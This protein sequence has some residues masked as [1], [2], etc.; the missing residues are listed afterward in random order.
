[1]DRNLAEKLVTELGK[2]PPLTTRVLSDENYFIDLLVS[3]EVPVS[4]RFY[5]EVKPNHKII[6]D[7]ANDQ[8]HFLSLRRILR[9]NLAENYKLSK[10]KKVYE[11]LAS[12]LGLYDSDVLTR[13]LR[14]NGEMAKMMSQSEHP[15]SLLAK[16]ETFDDF[17]GK[18]AIRPIVIIPYIIDLPKILAWEEANTNYGQR[19]LFGGDRRIS[20]SHYLR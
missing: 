2:H 6:E 17:S 10:T 9:N 11:A 14:A 3:T 13:K 15:Y 16:L 12:I 1:M 4:N 19:G 5:E 8:T 20:R 18:F 7:P